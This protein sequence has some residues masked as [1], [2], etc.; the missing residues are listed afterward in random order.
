MIKKWTVIL[1][2]MGLIVVCA[3]SNVFSNEGP[4]VIIVGS[5]KDKN[6]TP[7]DQEPGSSDQHP[8]EENN[9]GEEYPEDNGDEVENPDEQYM[10]EQE[11]QEQ[12]DTEESEEN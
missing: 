2:V 9:Q 7:H 6:E 5:E 1:M 8:M 4:T 11:E 3:F 10:E 12:E